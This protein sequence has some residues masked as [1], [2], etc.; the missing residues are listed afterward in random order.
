MLD[1]Y[2]PSKVLGQ[3]GVD[4]VLSARGFQVKPLSVNLKVQLPRT[5]GHR[6]NERSSNVVNA[7]QDKSLRQTTS[8][9]QTTLLGVIRTVSPSL[10]DPKTM[11]NDFVF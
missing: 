3:S 7:M 5:T 8:I 11:G 2:L 1:D 6:F 9:N 10:T 4:R